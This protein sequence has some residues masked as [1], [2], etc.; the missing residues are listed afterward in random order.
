MALANVKSFKARAQNSAQSTEQ[1]QGT[2]LVRNKRPGHW[3]RE[4]AVE[5]VLTVR[6]FV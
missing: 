2:E 5:E 1:S 4:D 3:L 6:Y